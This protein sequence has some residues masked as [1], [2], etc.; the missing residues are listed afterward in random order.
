VSVIGRRAGSTPSSVSPP[1]VRRQLCPGRLKAKAF[2]FA[3]PATARPRPDWRG[4]IPETLWDR[5]TA[6]LTRGYATVPSAELAFHLNN[7]PYSA[8]IEGAAPPRRWY[9]LVLR[10]NNPVRFLSA[11]R[12]LIPAGNRRLTVL[13]STKDG[14]ARET[15][16]NS[17]VSALSSAAGL[18]QHDQTCGEVRT[19][20]TSG[21]GLL[22][23]APTK[24]RSSGNIECKGPSAGPSAEKSKASCARLGIS[25]ITMGATGFEASVIGHERDRPAARR[26]RGTIPARPRQACRT[27]AAGSPKVDIFSSSVCSIDGTLSLKRIVAGGLRIP[28]RTYRRVLTIT[29]GRL[30]KDRAFASVT[31]PSTLSRTLI[32]PKH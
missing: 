18:V 2:V 22:A 14:V 10:S 30:K 3:I 26:P 8:A 19:A 15:Y 13:N 11:R 9:G 16:R 25:Q 7:I 6:P 31:G 28:K 17:P 20:T 1:A 23:S 5:P 12:T 24:C 32:G 21:D 29:K 27:V 4:L